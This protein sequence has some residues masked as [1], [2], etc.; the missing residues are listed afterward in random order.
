MRQYQVLVD[1][2]G[3]AYMAQL[4]KYVADKKCRGEIR[5]EKGYLYGVLKRTPT[6]E[7]L[8]TIAD[9]KTVE[10]SKYKQLQKQADK[11][12]QHQI[13]K[14]KESFK[15]MRDRITDFLHSK[16]QDEVSTLKTE[17][18]DSTFAKGLKFGQDEVDFTKSVVQATFTRYLFTKYLVE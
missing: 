3:E 2:H 12:E 10:K 7:S 13:Q 15:T 17:F 6:I 8:Q 11:V 14:Q 1:K 18:N 16:S 4:M 5:S 9:I